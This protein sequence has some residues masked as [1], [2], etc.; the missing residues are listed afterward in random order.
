MDV[1]FPCSFGDTVYYIS[2]VDNTT[3]KEAVVRG[4]RFYQYYTLYDVYD[5][6][7]NRYFVLESDE[8]YFTKEEAE[9]ALEEGE[10]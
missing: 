3:I 5:K 2:E 8:I 4:F 7:E 9:E 6:E 1:H 10:Q